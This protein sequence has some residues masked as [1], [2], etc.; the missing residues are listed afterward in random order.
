MEGEGS[1]DFWWRAILVILLLAVV[2]SLIIAAVNKYTTRDIY[3]LYRIVWAL[4]GLTLFILVSKHFG[5]RLS[6]VMPG[7]RASLVP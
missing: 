5:E 6:G 7:V 1:T 4:V 3:G 2:P